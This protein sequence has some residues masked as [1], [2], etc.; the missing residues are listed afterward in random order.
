MDAAAE[1][2]L[3]LKEVH[4]SSDDQSL[5]RC[6]D[7]IKSMEAFTAT[8]FTATV[9]TRLMAPLSKCVRAFRHN[10]RCSGNI[11]ER[12]AHK[13]K[14]LAKKTKLVISKL[15]DDKNVVASKT[16]DT[17]KRTKKESGHHQRPLN[18][19]GLPKTVKD[20]RHRLVTLKR[21]LYKDPPIAP[22]AAVAVSQC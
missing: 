3:L 8:K 12:S 21:D 13:W 22:P 15:E 10:A 20:Y 4:K 5:E 17:K 9:K 1:L 6:N 16:S 14:E 7:I 19:A 11:D 18:T 2:N